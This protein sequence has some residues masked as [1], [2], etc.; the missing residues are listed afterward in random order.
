MGAIREP[1][2]VKI[3]VG[4]LAKDSDA[5]EPVRKTLRDKFA[6]RDEDAFALGDELLLHERRVDLAL[7]QRLD[8]AGVLLLVRRDLVQRTAHT[9][10]FRYCP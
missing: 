1:A 8:L 6:F 10:F 3:V 4:I 5:V 7:A 9:R 2:K